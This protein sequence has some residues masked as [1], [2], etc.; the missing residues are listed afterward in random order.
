ME[1]RIKL[2]ARTLGDERV[3]LDVDLSDYMETKLGA[4]C[5]AFYIA[6]TTRELI[7]AVQL[8]RDL[9]IK[10]LIM[11]TGS[12]MAI[13]DKGFEGLVIKNRSD[14]IKIFGIKGKV[15]R[16]GIGIE[17]AFLEADSGT[18]IAR[19]SGYSA[20]QGLGGFETIKSVLG[21]IG[22]SINILP[23]LRDKTHQVKILNKSGLVKVK[24]PSGVTREDIILSVV[25]LLKARGIMGNE[26]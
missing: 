21:T 7:R 19:L 26:L 11:G 18:S 20:Q 4:S 24:Q 14:N 16:A 15:S 12:K 1:D 17:E 5:L 6:T 13:S 8:C 2:L 9:K 3:K 23:I 22:G 10:Y 25:F